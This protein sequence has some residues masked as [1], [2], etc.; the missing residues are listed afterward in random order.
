[1]IQSLCKVGQSTQFAA[2]AT[3][4][5]VSVDISTAASISHTLCSILQGSFGPN[6]LHNMI[7]TATGQ[8]LISSDG[9]TIL[10]SLHLSHPVGN[11]I[12]DAVQSYHA[13]TG[14]G[15]K[16]FLLILREALQTICKTYGIERTHSHVRSQVQKGQ[17]QQLCIQ[18]SQAFSHLLDHTLP[19]VILPA[20]LKHAVV[21]D[22]DN[23][24]QRENTV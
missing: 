18:M 19:E 14:D 4:S 13:I 20:I 9:S 16:T 8:V 24:P 3:M 15:T 1:M 6:A 17:V 21:T 10:K 7:S 2:S 11:L 22:F 23:L 12:M 5:C